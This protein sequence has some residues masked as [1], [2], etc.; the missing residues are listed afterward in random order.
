MK[1]KRLMHVFLA[2]A[3]CATLALSGCGK[4][5]TST[6]EKTTASSTENGSLDSTLEFESVDEEVTTLSEVKLRESNSID[7]NVVETVKAG[8]TLHRVGYNDVWSQIEFNGVTLYAST[9]YLSAKNNT[10]ATAEQSAQANTEKTTTAPAPSTSVEPAVPSTDPPFSGEIASL[11]NTSINW[12]FNIS[13]RDGENRPNGCLYYQRLYGAYADFVK[14]DTNKIYLTMDEGYEAGFT[15]KILDTLKEKNVKALFFIT[16]QFVTENPALVQRMID[17]GHVIG[18]H[19]SAHPAKGMP[20]LGIEGQK[21]DIMWMHNYVKDNFGYEMKFF[22]Y[23]S[24]IFSK[25]SLA[26]VDSLGYRS[27]FWSFAHKDWITTEQPDQAESLK[28]VVDQLHP[29]AIYLLHAVSETNTEILG[30]FI[31]QARAAGYEFGVY[32]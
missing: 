30:Q 28:R 12:G 13:D 10:S 15:P 26:L 27:V 9:Q 5:G 24:G 20:T 22:R 18:N 1:C 31:D 29:G 11:D 32:Q 17:E 21:E 16:K 2:T 6:D 3:L 4:K 19:S 23:P 25:Q 14:E 8:E 7:A